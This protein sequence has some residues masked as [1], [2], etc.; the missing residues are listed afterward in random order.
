MILLDRESLLP[1]F[2]N[3]AREREKPS[4]FFPFSPANFKKYLNNNA[5]KN[6]FVGK[7]TC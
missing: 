3:K 2:I 4:K 1:Y 6:I 5:L 7:G